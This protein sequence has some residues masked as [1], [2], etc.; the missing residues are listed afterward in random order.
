MV[1]I[2]YQDKKHVIGIDYG[3][4]RLIATGPNALDYAIREADSRRM[5]LV[6]PRG[7]SVF[8]ALEKGWPVVCRK[9]IRSGDE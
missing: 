1:T 8:E 3:C 2:W 5:D 4:D 7:S 6:P 9:R